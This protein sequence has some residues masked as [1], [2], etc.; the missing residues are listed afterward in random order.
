MP[1][2]DATEQLTKVQEWTLETMKANQGRVVELNGKLASLVEKLPKLPL[3]LADRLPDQKVMVT[4]YFDFVA[5]STEANRQFAEAMVDVWTG[6][7]SKAP[8]ADQAVAATPG[9][10]RRA[11]RPRATAKPRAATKAT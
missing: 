7:A 3:P 8:T 10:K 11:S 6:A 1:R 2:A 9:P 4:R 5:K